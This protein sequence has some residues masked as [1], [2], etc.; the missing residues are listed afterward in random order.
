MSSAE[1]IKRKYHFKP[2]KYLHVVY[3]KKCLNIRYPSLKSN[4]D[5]QHDG[6][7]KKD[8]QLFA[9]NNNRELKTWKYEPHK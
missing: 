1:T 2:Y 6:Q 8:K 9:K 5:R 7:C 3:E 4:K